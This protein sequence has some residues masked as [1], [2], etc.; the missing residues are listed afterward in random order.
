MVPAKKP[1]ELAALATAA[2]PG[3]KVTALKE[4]QYDDDFASV[5]GLLDAEGNSWTVVA[6]K[7]AY[8][9]EE[10]NAQARLLGMLEKLRDQ[11]VLPFSIPQMR[12]AVSTGPSTYTF[13]FTDTG[14]DPLVESQVL[15]DGLLAASLGRALA[16]LHNVDI[17]AFVQVGVPVSS[18]ETTRKS[19]LNVLATAGHEVPVRLRQRWKI[20]LEEPTLW[21]ADPTVIHGDMG[22]ANVLADGGAVISLTGFKYLRV[23]D[24]AVDLAWLLSIADENFISRFQS[25]YSA[26]R[27]AP[28]LHLLTR[29]QLH[30][31]IALLQWLQFGQ[32]SH[33]QQVVA[34]A[35]QMLVDLDR[36]LDGGLLVKSTQPVEDI[37][38]EAAD[39]PLNQLTAKEAAYSTDRDS[40]P[41]VGNEL[42]DD[43]AT[44]VFTSGNAQQRPSQSGASEYTPNEYRPSEHR[45]GGIARFGQQH[46]PN[47]SGSYEYPASEYPASDASSIGSSNN[48][49]GLEA[50]APSD[51]SL[52]DS[53]DDAFFDP[54]DKQPG[55]DDLNTVPFST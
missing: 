38:F 22:L 1:L 27:R 34:D 33:D 50:D 4:P 10:V 40:S 7:E 6:S 17:S 24:P 15:V 37:H 52:D 43:I 54:V 23:D 25:T 18:L 55:Q 11:G 32:E 30:S 28:D 48:E 36:D 31:E 47:S 8:S 26:H 41:E 21:S 53:L 14:G 19:L 35:R 45:S 9:E 2:V 13:V 12:G 49:Q 3:L 39:E 16:E 29:A 20:A 5:S 46:Q 42:A 51:D 44:E